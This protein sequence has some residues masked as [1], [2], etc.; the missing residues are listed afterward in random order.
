MCTEMLNRFNRKSEPFCRTCWHSAT[1]ASGLP[2]FRTLVIS[3]TIVGGTVKP[4][5]VFLLDILSQHAPQPSDIDLYF[6]CIN[7]VPTALL[8]LPS[9]CDTAFRRILFLMRQLMWIFV[10]L[11]LIPFCA[12][13]SEHVCHACRLTSLKIYQSGC[14]HRLK[15]RCPIFNKQFHSWQIPSLSHP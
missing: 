4:F 10:D 1:Q 15:K 2:S 6:I 8:P 13:F 3:T 12:V 9:R 5:I 11:Y 14:S 7:G